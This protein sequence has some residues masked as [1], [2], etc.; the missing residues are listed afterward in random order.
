MSATVAVAS[1]PQGSD[2]LHT[3]FGFFWGPWCQGVL[4]CTTWCASVNL[5]L[6]RGLLTANQS[7]VLCL[8]EIAKRKLPDT[9]ATKLDSAVRMVEGTARSLGLVV[10]D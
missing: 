7:A 3:P 8:Q 10:V 1:Q 2:T 6:Q 5:I 9:N 4:V